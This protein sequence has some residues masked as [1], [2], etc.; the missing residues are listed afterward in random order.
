[1]QPFR[2]FTYLHCGNALLICCTNTSCFGGIDST[3]RT[4][5]VNIPCLHLFTGI[6]EL[7]QSCIKTK[8][9]ASTLK[10]SSESSWF[11]SK[12]KSYVML[13]II[14][15]HGYCKDTTQYPCCIK[16]IRRKKFALV[17]NLLI[18]SN[19][20]RNYQEIYQEIWYLKTCSY[21]KTKQTNCWSSK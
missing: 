19:H 8:K 12:L 1:M 5:L 7:V 13:H 18:A 14:W 16:L 17:F 6:N 21:G 10:L 9:R 11:N 4:F 2:S 20:V 15:E 3:L